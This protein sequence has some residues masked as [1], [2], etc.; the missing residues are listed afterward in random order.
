MKHRI[1]NLCGQ[2]PNGRSLHYGPVCINGG[3]QEQPICMHCGEDVS[4]EHRVEIARWHVQIHAMLNRYKEK[5][6]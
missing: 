6:R 2:R 5:E 4:P 3:E 1:Y